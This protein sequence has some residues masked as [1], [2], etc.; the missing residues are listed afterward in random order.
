MEY[1]LLSNADES[2]KA[3]AIREREV[4]ITSEQDIAWIDRRDAVLATITSTATRRT[5]LAI[6]KQAEILLPTL[7]FLS[8]VVERELALLKRSGTAVTD[9]H[10]ARLFDALGDIVSLMTKLWSIAGKTSSPSPMVNIMNSNTAPS[11]PGGLDFSG[12]GSASP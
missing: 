4:E 10:F 5:R 1:A 2:P 6:M 12:W 3:W 7:T 8:E 9:G 11:G